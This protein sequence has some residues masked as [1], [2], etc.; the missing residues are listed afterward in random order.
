[1]TCTFSTKIS[2]NSVLERLTIDGALARVERE[3]A[4]CANG[5]SVPTPSAPPLGA[6]APHFMPTSGGGA[7]VV[8]LQQPF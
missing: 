1:M 8:A 5:E 4:R 6:S 3:L 2:C 7:I